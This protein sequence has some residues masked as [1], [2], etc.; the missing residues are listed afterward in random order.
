MS[1]YSSFKIMVQNCTT[2][3]DLRKKETSLNRL[4]DSGVLTPNEFTR[5]DYLIMD[6]Y[7][8][9]DINP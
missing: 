8:E 1:N 7:I 6:R 5:I 3:D 4:W 9:L 2:K